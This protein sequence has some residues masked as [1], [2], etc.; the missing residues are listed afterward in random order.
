MYNIHLTN[1]TD[2]QACSK[3]SN[4]IDS[5]ESDLEVIK[6]INDELRESVNTLT[7][8][9]NNLEAQL[10]CDVGSGKPSI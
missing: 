7:A 2:Y 3:N 10:S 9:V 1:I 8:Q 5:L 6:E 4:R